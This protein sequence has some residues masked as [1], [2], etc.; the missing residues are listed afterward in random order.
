MQ[1]TDFFQGIQ[2]IQWGKKS[3][4]N[5]IFLEKLDMCVWEKFNFFFYSTYKNKI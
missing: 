2:L 1:P 4:L 3:P 5:K